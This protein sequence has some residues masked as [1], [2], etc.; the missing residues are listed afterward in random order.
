MTEATNT[1][2][3]ERL[4]ALADS[5]DCLTEQDFQLLTGATAGTIEAWRKRRQGPDYIRLGNNYFYPRLGIAE[6][7]RKLTRE[8]N[9]LGKALL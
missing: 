1:A 4:R 5:L 2:E 6:H 3:S 8:R 7:M 9:T